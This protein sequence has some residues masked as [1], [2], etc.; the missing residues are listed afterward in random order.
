M[1]PAQ[2]PETYWKHGPEN[3]S[4]SRAPKHCEN[5]KTPLLVESTHCIPT[6]ETGV[7]TTVEEKK[8][9]SGWKTNEGEGL[10]Y[11]LRASPFW[12]G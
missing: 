8:V 2:S 12:R 11:S 1:N 4:F 3:M 9:W 7:L 5:L 10:T 6:P